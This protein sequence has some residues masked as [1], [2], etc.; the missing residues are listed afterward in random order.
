MAIFI[1]ILSMLKNKTHCAPKTIQGYISLKLMFSTSCEM[2]D[3]DSFIL[4]TVMCSIFFAKLACTLIRTLR[5][6]NNN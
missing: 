1:S 3:Y 6:N 2:L 4:R 5:E